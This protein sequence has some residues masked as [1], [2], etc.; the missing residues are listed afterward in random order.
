MSR[1]RRKESPKTHSQIPRKSYQNS[2]FLK[3]RQIG[4]VEQLS[5]RCR[6]HWAE[7]AFLSSIDATVEP[8]VEF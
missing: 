7:T 4:G 1:V 5:S 8:T 6:A 3:P 2:K